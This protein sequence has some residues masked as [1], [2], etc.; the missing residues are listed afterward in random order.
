MAHRQPLSTAI[1][2]RLYECLRSVGAPEAV[3]RQPGLPVEEIRALIADI[4]G[5]FPSEA[6]LWFS[7]TTWADD[8]YYMLPSLRYHTLPGCLVWYRHELDVSRQLA[9]IR[10]QAGLGELWSEAWLPISYIDGGVHLVVDVSGSDGTAAPI[11]EVYGQG[12]G[13]QFDP[14]VA[15]SLGDYITRSLDEID[16]GQWLYDRENHIWE[17]KDGW[18]ARAEHD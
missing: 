5:R 4:P 13:E 11:R 12:V 17:P 18:P 2:E 16:A 14:V 7:W 1:L 8:G 15:D 10:R 3:D 9:P 6:E